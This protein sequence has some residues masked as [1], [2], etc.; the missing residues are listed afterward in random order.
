MVVLGKKM[1]FLTHDNFF[2]AWMQD[3]PILTCIESYWGKWKDSPRAEVVTTGDD[4]IFGRVVETIIDELNSR[5]WT[6][7]GDGTTVSPP[8]TVMLAWEDFKT[9]FDPPNNPH[10]TTVGEVL[11]SIDAIINVYTMFSLSTGMI[12][13]WNDPDGGTSDVVTFQRYHESDD[14]NWIEDGGVT[15]DEMA[16]VSKEGIEMEVL[17]SE[18]EFVTPD[19]FSHMYVYIAHYGDDFVWKNP[20]PDD[21]LKPLT[22]VTFSH[23]LNEKAVV[24]LVDGI[25]Q[26]IHITELM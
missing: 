10:P 11:N 9:E 17:V 20:N 4:V 12:V 8:Q 7:W 18:L 16:F 3:S 15:G 26:E 25:E 2:N 19:N 21:P 6:E 24:V 23:M 1:D 5:C 13:F 22:E 14:P